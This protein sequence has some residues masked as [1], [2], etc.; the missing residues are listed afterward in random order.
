MNLTAT[1]GEER[2]YSLS[3]AEV[4]ARPKKKARLAT[5]LKAGNKNLPSIPY[6]VPKD[7]SKTLGPGAYTPHMDFISKRSPTIKMVSSMPKKQK[8]N[9]QLHSLLEMPLTT[10]E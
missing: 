2:R 4:R 9:D 6:S 7:S 1:E 5:L 10:T 3:L 8:S